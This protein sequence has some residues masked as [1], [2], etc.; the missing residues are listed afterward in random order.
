MS[1]TLAGVEGVI[2]SDARLRAGEPIVAGTATTV[3]AI[4]ELWN[5]GIA[6]EEITIHLPHLSLPQVF[7]ALGY[8]L[9]HRS[10]IDDFIAANR[11][12]HSWHGKRLDVQ[13]GKTE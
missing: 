10:E 3:R 2:H 13:T 1:S 4:A 11:I 7:A 9:S 5:Q 6:A 12:P 8:Y